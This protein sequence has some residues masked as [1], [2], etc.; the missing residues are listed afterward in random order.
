M[1]CSS[2]KMVC[3]IPRRPVLQ[4]PKCSNTDAFY[5]RLDRIRARRI[6]FAPTLSQLGQSISDILVHPLAPVL[7]R[8][9]AYSHA[10]PSRN[11]SGPRLVQTISNAL[12]VLSLLASS[13]GPSLASSRPLV[14]QRQNVCTKD[15]QKDN[16]ECSEVG[17]SIQLGVSCRYGIM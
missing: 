16:P 14:L 3:L 17:Y 7:W 10:Y 15:P 13:S 11:V 6:L 2:C 8:V 4:Y 12:Y 1:T 9:C 5:S